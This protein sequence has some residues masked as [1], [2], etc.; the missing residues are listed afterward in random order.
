MVQRPVTFS[1]K[2]E[3]FGAKGLGSRLFAMYM[4][5]TNQLQI[6]REGRG[7]PRPRWRRR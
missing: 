6:D 3:Y 7:P 5:A 4:K 2:S 1:A